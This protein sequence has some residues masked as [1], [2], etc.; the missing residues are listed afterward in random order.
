MARIQKNLTWIVLESIVVACALLKLYP[1]VHV[2][3]LGHCGAI[4]HA[5]G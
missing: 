1:K 3:I 5:K 2:V 4:N